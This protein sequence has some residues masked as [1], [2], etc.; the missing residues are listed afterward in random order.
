MHVTIVYLSLSLKGTLINSA[1]D[2]STIQNLK[3]YNSRNVKFKIFSKFQSI[4]KMKT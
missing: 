3:L 2:I 4:W 1:A